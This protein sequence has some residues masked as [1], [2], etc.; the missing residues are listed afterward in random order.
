MTMIWTP[1]KVKLLTII[2]L[3]LSTTMQQS[4]Y[5]TEIDPINVY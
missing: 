2:Y 3:Y 4:A 5:L 1:N